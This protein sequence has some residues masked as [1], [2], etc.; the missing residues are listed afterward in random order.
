MLDNLRQ[1]VYSAVVTAHFNYYVSP[2]CNSSEYN[3]EMW[4]CY[5]GVVNSWLFDQNKFKE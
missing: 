2:Q 5:D 4:F 1:D 3:L